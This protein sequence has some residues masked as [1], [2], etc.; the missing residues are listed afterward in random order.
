MLV[1]TVGISFD[2][3]FR[4]TSV[5]LIPQRA[6]DRRRSR[7]G[8]GDAAS[9]FVVTFSFVLFSFMPSD[10]RIHRVGK[11]LLLYHAQRNH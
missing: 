10:P 4:A 1:Y 8:R 11:T 9:T 3:Q 7:T 5:E 2:L 6:S